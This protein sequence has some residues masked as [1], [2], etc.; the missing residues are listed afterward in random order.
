[1]MSSASGGGAD[2]M[3]SRSVSSSWQKMS[4]GR[5]LTS[6]PNGFSISAQIEIKPWMM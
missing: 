3:M 2:V 4:R 5:S 1:M 6:L